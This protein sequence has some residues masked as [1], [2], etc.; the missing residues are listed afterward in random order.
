MDEKPNTTNRPMAVKFKHRRFQFRLRTLMIGVTL[1]AVPC[2]YVGWQAKIVR[3]RDAMRLD[4]K[5]HGF[6]TFDDPKLV[7]I[8]RR[9]LGDEGYSTILVPRGT[10]ADYIAKIKAIFPE[11]TVGS[12]SWPTVDLRGLP[13]RP[14]QPAAQP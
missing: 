11:S 13:I 4:L 9:W 1:L 6:V 12:G 3:E 2:A 10:S 8:V 14:V 7:P 5:D